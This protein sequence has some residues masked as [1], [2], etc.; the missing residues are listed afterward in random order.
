MLHMDA[1]SDIYQTYDV[2]HTLYSSLPQGCQQAYELLLIAIWCAE[3]IQSS[4][5]RIPLLAEYLI[6][7]YAGRVG[8]TLPLASKDWALS[9]SAA[10]AT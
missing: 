1:Y 2:A 3:V 6:G 8:L 4:F 9:C 7:D 5:S 10:R